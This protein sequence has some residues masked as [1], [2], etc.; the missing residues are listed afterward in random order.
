MHGVNFKSLAKFKSNSQSG[1]DLQG[2]AMMGSNKNKTGLMK[3]K[4][5]C[6]C[7]QDANVKTEFNILPLLENRSR[8]EE[9]GE[10]VINNTLPARWP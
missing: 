7:L 4:V 6:L 8:K 5:K 1:S 3:R 2:K 10:G 9:G